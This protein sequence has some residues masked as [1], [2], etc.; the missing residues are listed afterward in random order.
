MELHPRQRPRRDAGMARRARRRARERRTGAR[1]LPHRAADRSGAPLRR[2]PPVLGEH[3][4]H[5][6]DPGGGAGT[7]SRHLRHRAAHPPLRALERDGRGGAREQGH[8]RRRPHRELRLGGDA[9]RHRLQ[10]F[11]ARPV[12]DP[13]RRPRLRAGPFG[14][15]RLRAGVHARTPHRRA[16]GQLPPGSRRPRNL[17]VPPSVADAGILAVS[18]GVDGSRAADG[19]L[20][21]ALHEV[22]A[23]PRDHRRRG[24][25]GLVLLRR[26]RDG[27]AGV[28]G[29]DRHGGTREPRQPDLR[30]QLQPAAPRRPGARQQQDHPGAR[31]RFPRF[32]LERHQGGLGPPLGPAVRPRQEGNPDAA[33]DGGRRRRVPD[34][35][36]E[37]RRVR[38]R[39]FLQHPGAEGARRRL[40]GRRRLEVEPRRPRPVQGVRRL[41]RRGQS[42][43]PAD[44]HPRQDDQGLR[45]GRFR[46]G[47]EH[48]APA[49]EDVA[50]VDPPLPRPVQHPRPRRQARRSPV[51][52]V[53]GR[54]A[55]GRVHARAAQGARRLPADAAHEGRAAGDPRARRVRALPQEHRG[56]RDLDDDG[57][58]PDPPAAAARQEPREA[59]RADRPRR[60]ADV[61][62]GGPVPPARHLEP[63]GAALHAAGRRPADVLQGEQG[64]PDP[65]G[66]D[67]RAGRRCATGSRRRPRTRRTA[68]R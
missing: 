12:R 18:D 13:R 54:L 48:H 4:V 17:V 19:D 31:E 20:S 40:V 1:A 26:R 41:P 53:P 32:R 59:H 5:Q 21:G 62:H 63:E 36:V 42:Q 49:E 3:R 50:R 67:Q 35:Q 11:L 29:R 16:D 47:A 8:Q 52:H 37:E 27:R 10:P 24:P 34:D 65:A 14:A 39:A 45:H 2:L 64:R 58:R 60:V 57:V 43:G 56:A 28:D 51:R 15:R 61:R 46:R 44:R 68:C 22:P 66:G 30:R 55:R 7:A 23:R 9:L 25:Q 33:D 38:A 6:H